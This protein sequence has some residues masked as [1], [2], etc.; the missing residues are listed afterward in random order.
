MKPFTL[1]AQVATLQPVPG[2]LSLEKV[3]TTVSGAQSILPLSALIIGSYE[4]PQIYDGLIDL[5]ARRGV[6]AYLW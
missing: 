6:D 2:S 4:I 5:S 3:L 1:A